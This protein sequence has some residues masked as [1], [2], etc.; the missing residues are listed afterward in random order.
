MSVSQPQVVRMLSLVPYLQS[1]DGIPIKQVAKDFGVT[2]KQI[3]KDLQVLVFCGLPGGLPGDLIDID[4]EAL[5]SDGVI[6]IRDAE[7]LTRPLRTGHSEALS[8]IVALRTL[9]AA[10]SKAE[11]DIINSA[12]A[13]LEDAIGGGVNAA[14]DV[15]V[16]PVDAEIQQVLTVA[17]STGLRVRITYTN[18][19][20]DDVTHRD[21]D[22]VRVFSSQGHLYV[23][24]W[25]LMVDGPRTFRLD[26]ILAAEAT[27]E[28]VE[29]HDWPDRSA[30]DPMFTPYEGAPSA[31]LDLEPD[32]HWLGEYYQVES[33]EHFPNG[34]WRVKLYA[35][36]WRWLV[37]LVLRNG[38]SVRV[39]EPDMLGADV[40]SQAALSL[41]AYADD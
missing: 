37:R 11:R 23:E 12:L 18:P 36:N 27:R 15:H 17:A 41:V 2:A 8:L 13:K 1:H 31:I 14:V 30:S 5:E 6:H 25:C 3:A 26:R 21:I 34:V 16:E 28:T 40:R 19:A 9:R 4:Y 29:D 38:R 10:A 24:S 32:A 20:R 7:F 33:I 22:P 35:A 39:V